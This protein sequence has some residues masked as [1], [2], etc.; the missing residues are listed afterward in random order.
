MKLHLY[1]MYTYIGTDEVQSNVIEL[2]TI[3]ISYKQKRV[4]ATSD[5]L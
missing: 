1:R 5:P 2:H 3:S 4:N